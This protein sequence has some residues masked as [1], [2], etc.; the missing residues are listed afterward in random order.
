MKELWYSSSSHTGDPNHLQSAPPELAGYIQIPSKLL[1]H[2]RHTGQQFARISRIALPSIDL[3]LHNQLKGLRG[4]H[5]QVQERRINNIRFGTSQHQ[6]Q[7][8]F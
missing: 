8:G 1:Q 6:G 7:S 5:P 3:L 2:I 4:S